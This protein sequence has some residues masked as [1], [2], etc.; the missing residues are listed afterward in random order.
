MDKNGTLDYN[1]FQALLETIAMW[2]K[3]FFKFDKDRSGTLERGEVQEA[4][5]S[6]SKEGGGGLRFF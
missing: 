2:K 5:R 4:I 1:E 3:M 6:L